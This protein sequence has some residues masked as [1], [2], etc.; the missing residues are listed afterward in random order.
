MST[1]L[2]LLQEWFSAFLDFL[3]S[4][5]IGLGILL[6]SWILSRWL[7]RLVRRS[8]KRS[9]RDPELIV[10]ISLLTRYGLLTLG[11][12]VAIEIMTGG[13][14][15]SLIAGLGIAGFTVGFALQDVAKNF[16]AGIMLLLQQPF[17]IGDSVEVSGYAGHV[18]A[19]T[20]RTTE[21][22]LLDGRFVLIP[23]ADVF[24][25][26]VV[27]LSRADQRRI[28]ITIGVAGDSDLDKVAR[29]A[30][31]A[32]RDIQGLL[33]DPSPNVAFENFGESTIDFTLYYWIGPDETAVVDARDEGIRALKLT[34]E[35]EGI[36]L[37]YPTM[38]VLTEQS[39]Q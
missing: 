16:V 24:T 18:H 1:I 37:P 35:R 4:L 5:G 33:E 6:L 12:V 32:I 11:I 10:L 9:D 39:A 20:L 22:R 27:N 7:S 19:I 8:M 36:V 31:E 26:A 21:L 25:S 23:N 17:G 29:L 13:A 28:E 14:L 30:L 3:P 38:T 34:F 2:D 15:V